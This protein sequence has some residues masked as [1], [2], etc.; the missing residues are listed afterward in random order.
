MLRYSR[1]L[2]S[3]RAAHLG[4]VVFLV[5]VSLVFSSCS[6]VAPASPVTSQPITLTIGY[7]HQTGQDPL[8]G[9]QQA[10]RLLSF[11]G[12]AYL[13]RDGRPRPRLA[14]SWHESEDRLTWS[15]K[16][17]K[18]ARFH[19]GSLVDATA[20][21]QSL[22]RSI[23]G[24]E[25]VFRPGLADIAAVEAPSS[26]E[27][28]LKLNAPSTFVI[29]D[30]TVAIVKNAN[31]EEIG[32]GPFVTTS[33]SPTEIVM[34]S[35]PTYYRSEPVINRIVWRAYPTVRTAWAAMM[36]G[37]IDFLYE[38]P[39]DALE[40]IEPEESVSVFPFLRNYV[41]AL[42][43]NTKRH[44]FD[45]PRVR[46]AL[47]YAV[48]RSEV[49]DLALH[50]R[51][52]PANGPTWPEH[53]AF[54]RSISE[55]GH[56]PSRATALLDAAGLPKARASAPGQ[57][58]AR[59]HFTCL[60]TQ[61]FALWERM[62]LIAQRDFAQV[63]VDMQFESVSFTELNQ[64]LANGNFDAVVMELVVGNSVSRPYF[65]WHSQGLLNAWGYRN[66]KVDAALDGVRRSS[67]EDLYRQSFRSLQSETLDDPPAVFLAL[68]EVARA[69]SK[70][71][72]VVAQQGTDIISTIPEW[73]LG[74]GTERVAN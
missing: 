41:Y 40:F 18:N 51:G 28:V 49:I 43:L 39:P 1:R 33:T 20:V 64:R 54:D 70:R 62:A 23:A 2:T 19:D 66:T 22:D 71:F 3:H 55:Y 46:R 69:V 16:L 24:R 74:E 8:H 12:L 63:G 50:G 42:A 27:I 5:L 56:D 45:S 37:D 21:K 4:C 29:D 44:P 17:R 47:N 53:W 13:A 7:P 26:S 9:V 25:K 14:E 34:T 15:I 32:S 6:R 59:L 35:V 30:L 38:V 48:D 10:A 61:N 52:K 65:F 67:S 57:V 31:G 11:E 68:G 60:V 73:Q 58:P 72:K 36:R